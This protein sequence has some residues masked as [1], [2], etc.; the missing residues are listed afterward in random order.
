MPGQVMPGGM[1]P[2]PATTEISG[3]PG[4]P[5][6]LTLTVTDPLGN[7]VAGFPV[8]LAAFGTSGVGLYFYN[9]F[10]SPTA[11]PGTYTGSWSGTLLGLPISATDT[12][13]VGTSGCAGSW[14]PLQAYSLGNI[15]T[16]TVSV[17]HSFVCTKAGTSGATDPAWVTR[18]ATITDGSAE[19][20]IYTIISPQDVR[21]YMGLDPDAN[22]RYS[23]QTIGSHIADA[24]VYLERAT[25]RHLVDRPCS[26]LL[27]TTMLRAQIPIPALRAA[28]SVTW[29]GAIQTPQPNGSY[30]LLPDPLQTGVFLSI[31]FRA[32]RADPGGA[33][34]Y[35]SDSQ[36]FDKA[37]DSPFYPGNYGGGTAYTSMPNDLVIV[38]DW[39]WAPGQEPADVLR[40]LQALAAFDTQ[41][42]VSILADV[43]ITPAG[44]VL[45]YS[46]LPAEARDFIAANRH[47]QQVVSVG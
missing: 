37:L 24:T 8:S 45:N 31:Q 9:W 16:P 1:H 43:A 14:R 32:Y 12:C 28:T 34:S 4:T 25:N 26:T 19:W 42:P 29:G 47:G 30:W 40:P 27:F 22:S 39:G 10:V 20:H 36:W 44:G 3:T 5:T 17:G 38:G 21:D 33:P 2:W 41:R 6:A 46:S 18:Y 7:V 13:T 23:D 35:L 11:L 15:V